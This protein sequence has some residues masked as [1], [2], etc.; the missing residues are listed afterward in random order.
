MNETSFIECSHRKRCLVCCQNVTSSLQCRTHI[1]AV[2]SNLSCN[3]QFCYK[4]FE[5]NDNLNRDERSHTGV[6]SYKYD[7]CNNY[8][9]DS[10]D[11][12]H[13]NVLVR[14]LLGISYFYCKLVLRTFYHKF[15]M[16]LFLS[17]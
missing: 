13:P 8:F 16:R 3:C 12:K 1:K 10:Y 11:L 7:D 5:T 14:L 15:M 6:L 4:S 9:Q 17:Y 2:N